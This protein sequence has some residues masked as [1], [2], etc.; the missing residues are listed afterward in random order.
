MERCTRADQ[1]LVPQAA[2]QIHLSRMRFVIAW[3]LDSAELFEPPVAHTRVHWAQT[4]Q[5]IPERFRVGFAPVVTKPPR[6]IVNDVEI[7]ANPLG[8]GHSATHA[9]HPALARSHGP[10]TFEG[11][12]CS[13]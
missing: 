3:P 11:A 1:R 7:V 10:F 13:G 8:H 6:E 2:V 12:G 4:A 9:L 5:F